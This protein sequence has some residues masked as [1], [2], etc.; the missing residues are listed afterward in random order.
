MLCKKC[1]KELQEDW[2]YCPWCGLNAKKPPKQTMYRRKDGLYE[3]IVVINKKRVAFRG[4]TEK[5]VIQK[6]AA[7]T[8][9][10]QD[11]TTAPF[12]KYAEELERSWD[13]L[14][15]N[16]LR[17][18]KPALRRCVET[19]GEV[20]ISE[21]TPLMVQKF[22]DSLGK[23]FAKKTV[24]THKSVL[25]QVFSIAI[26]AR[27][28]TDTPVNQFIKASG[29]APVTREEA[30]E[31]DRQKIAEHWDE[32]VISRLAYFIMMTGT[33]VGEALGMRYED[34][35]Y[36]KNTIEIWRTVY[37]VGSHP[38]LK[39]PKTKAGKRTIVLLP[40]LA[41]KFQGHGEIFLT[42]RG[43]L[44]RSHE[45]TRWWKKYRDK[46]GIE[47]TFHQLR[48]SF[49]TS[50]CEAGIDPKVVQQM[51]GHS[52]YIVTDHYTHIREEMLKKARE[53]L[54]EII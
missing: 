17:G 30:S 34:I 15:Y 18:Y 31:S 24:N 27:D 25:S 29:K 23:T 33:R 1:K 35:D 12:K 39:E 9:E 42:D 10:A 16:S 2:L 21:I 38:R 13:N 26:M 48:H 50:C 44:L 52:S 54:D 11:K 32:S 3:K 22:L 20:P 6:I 4:K 37:F 8:A 40:E 51:M 19:F 7:Y 47:C 14:A 49:A 36:E 45:V 28:I 43:A 5:E 41:E 46:Y 53:Q